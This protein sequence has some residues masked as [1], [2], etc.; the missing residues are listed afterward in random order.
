ML[1]LLHEEEEEVFIFLYVF[2]SVPFSTRFQTFLSTDNV[3]A[4]CFFFFFFCCLILLNSCK[5]VRFPGTLAHSN[6]ELEVSK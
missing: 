6:L 4:E 3:V 2:A 5:F 1:C